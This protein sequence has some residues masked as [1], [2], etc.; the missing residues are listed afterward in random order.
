MFTH[1]SALLLIYFSKSLLMITASLGSEISMSQEVVRN[2]TPVRGFWK[3]YNRSCHAVRFQGR[4]F[5]AGDAMTI[6]K[7]LLRCRLAELVFFFMKSI[8]CSCALRLLSS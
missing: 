7:I 1:R 5:S 2:E 4:K 6:D 8:I 3:R